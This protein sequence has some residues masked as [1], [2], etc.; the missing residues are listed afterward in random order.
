MQKLKLLICT[1]TASALLFGCSGEKRPFTA[2]FDGKDNAVVTYKGKSYTLNRFVPVANVPFK[3]RFE[4]D[5]D[6]DIEIEGKSY[7]V[8]NPYDIDKKKKTAKKKTKTVKKTSS[9]KKTSTSK[10]K[11]K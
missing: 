1:F 5:G 9:S 2:E 3:Y 6:L 11:K 8:D 10:N 7:E 4:S